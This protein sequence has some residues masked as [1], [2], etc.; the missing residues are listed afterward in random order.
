MKSFFTLYI[1]QTD[2]DEMRLVKLRH[3]NDEEIEVEDSS[4]EVHRFL[5]EEAS[6]LHDFSDLLIDFLVHI[7]YSEDGK[8]GSIHVQMDPLSLSQSLN[9]SGTFLS[10]IFPL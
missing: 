2:E 10:T 3:V 8:M 9:E 6:I 5:E 7:C 1:R 4:G